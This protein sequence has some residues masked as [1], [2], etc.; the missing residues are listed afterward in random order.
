M[1]RIFCPSR[2]AVIGAS[3]APENL[4][5]NIVFN[6]INFGFKGEF[7]AVGRSGGEVH[8]VPIHRDVASLPS[9]IDFAAILTPAPT[10]PAF[11]EQ[12]IARGARGFW[13]GTGGFSEFSEGGAELERRIASIAREAGAR[14]IGPNCWGIINMENG[15]CLPFGRVRM[16]PFGRTSILAQS[17]GVGISYLQEMAGENIGLSK[18]ASIGNKADVDEVD[19]LK[20][21]GDD[22]GTAVICLY[23]ESINRGREFAAAAAAISKPIILHKTNTTPLARTIAK[24]H[25]SSLA[26]DDAVLDAAVKSAGIIRVGTVRELVDTA[27]I[28]RLPPMKGRRMAVMSRSGGHAI[29]AADECSRLGFE[30]PPL[31]NDVIEK[32]RGRLR[33]GVISLGNPLDLGDLYDHAFYAEMIKMVLPLDSVDG[34]VLLFTYH[35]AMGMQVPED[36]ILTAKRLSETHGKPVAF[37]LMSWAEEASEIKKLVDFPI[38]QTTEEAIRALDRSYRYHLRRNGIPPAPSAI[39]PGGPSAARTI[40]DACCARGETL[41]S[42]DALG[43]IRAEGIEVVP[44]FLAH[45]I[46]EV[47]TLSTGMPVP[48]VLK[49]Q[50]SGVSHK[51]DAGGV[52]LGVSGPQDAVAKAIAMKDRVENIVPGA[53]VH[54]FILQET[55]PGGVEMFIGAGRDRSFGPFVTAGL[56]GVFVEIY[57]DVAT[58]PAPVDGRAALG[59]LQSLGGFPVLDGFRGRPRCDLDALCDAIVKVSRLIASDERISGIDVNPIVVYPKG[60][61][62]LAVDARM[63]LE[64][65]ATGNWQ[66]ATGYCSR[67]P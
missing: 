67:S 27:N 15:L 8:G 40:V 7:Y 6:L 54:G 23:L 4:A 53:K 5:A 25:T 11:M 18:F 61:G 66:L 32:V 41:V 63:T 10:V 20:F 3:P 60:L 47:R 42:Y 62:V 56:G 33:A 21:L 43:A 45:D 37:C 9:D 30:L 17:G 2:V 65:A 35:P 19:L 38:F 26:S 57:R 48:L 34:V 31:P 49:V 16:L 39:G 13:V 24:T 1:R 59:M 58:L 46:E 14:F 29:I 22:P 28:F 12:C 64:T 44:T 52:A 50:A 36:I 55:A 51:S